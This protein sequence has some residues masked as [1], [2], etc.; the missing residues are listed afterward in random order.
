MSYKIFVCANP[1]FG[2]WEP[3]LEYQDRDVANTIAMGFINDGIPVITYNGEKFRI[4]NA[5]QKH[6]PKKLN[7]NDYPVIA[8]EAKN[9][10]SCRLSDLDWLGLLELY[11]WTYDAKTGLKKVTQSFYTY[12]SP[13][14]ESEKLFSVTSYE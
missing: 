13:L 5:S 7:I 8:K 6:Q 14:F 1:Y 11:A 9:Y 4:W 3:T 2:T 10:E 12:S